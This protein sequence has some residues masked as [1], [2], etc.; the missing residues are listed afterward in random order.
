[1]MTLIRDTQ[2]SLSL[3]PSQ[4]KMCH[5]HGNENFIGRSECFLNI[6]TLSGYI[7]LQIRIS[8]TI[9]HV[10]DPHQKF[11]IRDNKG[12]IAVSLGSD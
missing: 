1:M 11:A 6:Q 8:S 9:T 4:I 7:F 2:E 10:V 3:I 12:E 5:N